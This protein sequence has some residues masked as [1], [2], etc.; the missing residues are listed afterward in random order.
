MPTIKYDFD[1]AIKLIENKGSKTKTELKKEAGITMVTLNSWIDKA[2][3]DLH[4]KQKHYGKVYFN[5][6]RD[7]ISKKY[8]IH[9]LGDNGSKIVAMFGYVFGKGL[10]LVPDNHVN[11]IYIADWYKALENF[12]YK[13]ADF[14]RFK[15]AVKV[16]SKD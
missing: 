15:K 2:N 9:S 8:V 5:M 1:T 10:F 4:S 14:D 16:H 6:Y 7:G 12:D 13:K 11:D 3:N